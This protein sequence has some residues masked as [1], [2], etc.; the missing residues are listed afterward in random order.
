MY[1]EGVRHQRDKDRNQRETK[2]TPTTQHTR[3]R[4]HTHTHTHTHNHRHA[5]TTHIRTDDEHEQRDKR[6]V[7]DG[8]SRGRYTWCEKINK[9]S[10][11]TVVLLEVEWAQSGTQQQSTRG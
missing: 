9:E 6:I 2:K 8:E 3:A 5:L 1:T 11:D 7:C 10:D 4:A